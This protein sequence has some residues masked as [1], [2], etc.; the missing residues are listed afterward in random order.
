MSTPARVLA[1]VALL[2]G[3]A[4]AA[5]VIRVAVD[6]SEAPRHILHTRLTIPA[7]PGPLDLVYPK[8]IPGEHTPSGPIEGMAGLR[9]TAGA[10]NVPWRRDSEE[11]Y[12]FH[13]EVP[14][15]ATELEVGFDQTS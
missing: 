10:R 6:A 4:T 9:I 14:A 8:W 5:P 13:L 7:R 12:T 3:P 11:M 1:L 15:G 2:A